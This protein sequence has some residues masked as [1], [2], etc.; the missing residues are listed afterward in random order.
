MAEADYK[1]N[2]PL[3]KSIPA[4][5]HYTPSLLYPLPRDATREELGLQTASLPFYG[6]DIWNLYEVSWLDEQGKPQVAVGQLEVPCESP[7]LI[8]SKSLK[9]YLN[10]FNQSRFPSRREV[11]RTIEA[12][13]S[14][15]LSTP[16][17]IKLWPLATAR[18]NA[19]AV[20]A[21]EC[22]D[23]I[24]LRVTHYHPDANLLALASGQSVQQQ[25]YTD[26]FRS[27][28][29]VTG[30]P[31]WASVQI[32]Y[33]GPPISKASLLQYLVSFRGH[34]GFHEQCVERIFVDIKARCQPQRLTV[35]ARF[36][37]RGGI[38]INPF[39]STGHGHPGHFRLVRQ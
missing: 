36:L 10:S 6:V 15:A 16:L 39:R 7:Y 21:G 33:S 2:T 37:R 9:L 1:S 8:E 38:D 19:L 24:E 31:D 11:A 34:S 20:M 5:D 14:A 22:L 26:L 27:R 23:D 17:S 18:G 30:Q 28:C 13:L 12:D 29:P 25:L 32:S 35:Y 3:G 4:V